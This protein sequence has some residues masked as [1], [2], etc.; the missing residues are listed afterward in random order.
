MARFYGNMLIKM[1]EEN[2]EREGNGCGVDWG[3]AV[4]KNLYIGYIKV[5]CLC[6]IIYSS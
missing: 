2:G 6:K 5:M 1:G 3:I 4:P